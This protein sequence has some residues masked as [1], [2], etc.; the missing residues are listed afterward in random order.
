MGESTCESVCLGADVHV[1]VGV[2]EW[3]WLDVCESARDSVCFGA[4]VCL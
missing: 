4:L 3:I 1:N 2:C